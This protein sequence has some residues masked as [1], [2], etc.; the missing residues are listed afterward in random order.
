LSTDAK[1]IAYRVKRLT[2]PQAAARLLVLGNLP[3]PTADEITEAYLLGDRLGITVE[4]ERMTFAE[5]SGV[6]VK[7]PRPNTSQ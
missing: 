7:Q 1:I 5:L 2:D 4:V 3:N 6:W